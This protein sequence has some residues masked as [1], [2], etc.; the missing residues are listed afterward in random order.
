MKY[1]FTLKTSAKWRS[2][3]MSHWS[4]FWIRK[5]RMNIWILKKRINNIPESIGI[6][7]TLFKW[8]V[9]YQINPQT[10]KW[11]QLYKNICAKWKLFLEMHVFVWLLKIRIETLHLYFIPWW[12]Q[13]L[14]LKK[15]K[16]SK[17]KGFI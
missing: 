8:E 11:A 9:L 14:L 13:P 5:N 10:L 6:A 16:V 7:I 1:I 15:K 4:I 12:F 3:P 2:I 17:Y